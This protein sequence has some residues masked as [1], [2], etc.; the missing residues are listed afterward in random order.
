MAKPGSKTPGTLA[1]VL[2]DNVRHQQ[3]RKEATASPPEAR[4]PPRERVKSAERKRDSNRSD[5]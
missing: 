3:Q 5:H 1:D 4:R 2:S